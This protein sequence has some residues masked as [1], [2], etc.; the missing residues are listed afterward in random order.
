MVT[1]QFHR[2]FLSETA[3]LVTA[4]GYGVKSPVSSGEATRTVAQ[5]SLHEP[6]GRLLDRRKTFLLSDAFE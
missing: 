4:V 5:S 2:D 3:A 1:L 6:F